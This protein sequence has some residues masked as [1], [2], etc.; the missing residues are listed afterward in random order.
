MALMG[1]PVEHQSFDTLGLILAASGPK[2]SRPRLRFVECAIYVMKAAGKSRIV[3]TA[4]SD[5]R[6]YSY[7]PEQ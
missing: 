1:L 3:I 7:A 6:I 4:K 2:A 5:V